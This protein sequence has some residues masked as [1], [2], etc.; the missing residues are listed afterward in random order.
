MR[1]LRRDD[2]SRNLQSRDPKFDESWRARLAVDVSRDLGSN[3]HRRALRRVTEARTT[4]LVF[5]R[6][7]ISLSAGDSWTFSGNLRTLCNAR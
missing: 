3:S 1:R 7:A 2:A 4:L 6:V 5:R